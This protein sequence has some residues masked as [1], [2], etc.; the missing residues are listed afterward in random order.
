MASQAGKQEVLVES[1][2]LFALRKGDRHHSKVLRALGMHKNGVLSIKG[3]SS[4]IMDVRTVL[5]SIGLSLGDVED[6]FFLMDAKLAEY[7]VRE[8]VPLALSDAILA[9]RMRS[10]EA[11]LGFFDSLHAATS[12]R[13]KLKLL[14]SEGIYREVGS[15]VMDLNGL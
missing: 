11:R 14:S 13:L 4:A 1:D 7:G 8:F 6:A 3:L 15:P 12:K 9:E 5:Y 2:F 10:D